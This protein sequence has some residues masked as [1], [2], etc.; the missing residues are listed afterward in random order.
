MN[1]SFKQ[2]LTRDNSIIININLIKHINNV[3]VDLFIKEYKISNLWN[4]KFFIKRLINKIFKYQVNKKMKWNKKIWGIIKI[5]KIKI[6]I[7]KEDIETTKLAIEK[8]TSANRYSDIKK[9]QKLIA[10]NNNVGDSLYITGRT[11]NYL[12]ASIE[13]DSIFILDGSR[14]LVANMLNNISPDILLI[15]LEEKYLEK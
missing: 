4:G 8:K 2:S 9:Y 3:N 13:K 14:R 15:D 7:S 1:Q 6:N 12:G 10:E 11:L 5:K